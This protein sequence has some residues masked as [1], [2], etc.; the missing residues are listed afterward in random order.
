MSTR[1]P[2]GGGDT[3][4][5]HRI[6]PAISSTDLAPFCNPSSHMEAGD[7][8]EWG[9]TIQYR[10][11]FSEMAAAVQANTQTQHSLTLA[12]LSKHYKERKNDFSAR[13]DK[14]IN[15]TASGHFQCLDFWLRGEKDSSKI[16]LKGEKVCFSTLC[17][18]ER[19]YLLLQ[20]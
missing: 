18:E 8:C 2:R 15:T 10:G 19:F 4:K 3:E 17:F 5:G 16:A 13:S 1:I 7:L 11:A 14:K 12:V 20:S 9:G 6:M